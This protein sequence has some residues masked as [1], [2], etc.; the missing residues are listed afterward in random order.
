MPPKEVKEKRP[1]SPPFNYILLKSSSDIVALN[2]KFSKSAVATI[3]DD[4]DDDDTDYDD[5]DYQYDDYYGVDEDCSKQRTPIIDNI[6]S[7]LIATALS[8]PSSSTS[9]EQ[10][11]LQKVSK[12][13]LPA[14]F[15]AGRRQVTSSI[16]SSDTAAR[17]NAFRRRKRNREDDQIN[18]NKREL[19]AREY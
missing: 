10:T 13:A 4:D 8:A 12:I 2:N 19:Y 6:F 7:S 16:I 15:I 18:V 11:P 9:T 1:R 5:F 3:Y 17:L 14:R